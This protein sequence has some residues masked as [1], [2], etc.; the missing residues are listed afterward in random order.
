[1]H[2]VNRP[3]E[4]KHDSTDT[5]FVLLQAI[6]R[7]DAWIGTVEAF[8]EY[9]ESGIQPGDAADD[10]A[11]PEAY[12]VRLLTQQCSPGALQLVACAQGSDSLAH[13]VNDRRF[14]PL[15]P[16]D[17]PNDKR[18][19]CMFAEV[20]LEG[21]PTLFVVATQAIARG[22]ECLLDYGD[23]YWAH[24]RQATAEMG[25]AVEKLVGRLRSSKL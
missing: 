18:A 11:F 23:A 12:V 5:V 19:N 24:H 4:N 1:M 14:N 6:D 17:N 10:G 16:G 8:A 22:E 21:V 15:E 9:K 2:A 3:S 7:Y 13:R 25:R 20:V